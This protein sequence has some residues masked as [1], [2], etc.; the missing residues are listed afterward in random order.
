MSVILITGCSSGFGLDTTVELSRRGHQVFA[1]MRDLLRADQLKAALNAAGLAARII[2][3][4]VTDP[5]SVSEAV[6]E[7]VDGAGR[8]DVVINNA[9]V[10]LVGPV[11]ETSS[12]ALWQLFETN[13][14][15]AHR[16]IQAALPTMRRQRSGHVVNVTSVGALV[17]PPFLGAYAASKHAL[18]ALAEALAVEVRP[19]GIQVTNVAPGAYETAM[20][21]VADDTL[22]SIPAESPYAER[23]R[24][25]T[26]AHREFMRQNSDTG[27]VARAIADAVEA[28]PVPARVVIPTA[29][30]LLA[31]A[32]KLG[33]EDVREVLARVY[34]LG[35]AAARP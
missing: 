11:E 30:A 22:S 18:D 28:D 7:V 16:V 25:M 29:A 21:Q 31:E 20:S 6:A 4:D 15:G 5:G 2:R 14:L 3:L 10:A 9:G 17:S 34:G 35:A 1:T 27:E 23:W 32:R 13:T 19:F 26:A 24:T 33:P 12:E 8:I